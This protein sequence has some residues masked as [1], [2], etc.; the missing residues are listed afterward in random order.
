MK[1]EERMEQIKEIV[2]KKL[3]LTHVVTLDESMRLQEDLLIDSIMLLQLIVYIEEELQLMVP[4]KELDPRTFLTVGSLLDFIE[5][6]QPVNT[7]AL[8]STPT[9]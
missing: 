1:R 9:Q 8:S 4:A 2:T 3:K 5:Q 6:L 7:T